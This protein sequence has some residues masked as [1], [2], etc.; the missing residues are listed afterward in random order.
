MMFFFLNEHID[1]HDKSD[2]QVF[3]RLVT[4]NWQKE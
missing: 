2:T 1:F 4:G 3:K